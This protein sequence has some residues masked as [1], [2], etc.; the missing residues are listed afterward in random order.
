MNQLQI[1][2]LNDDEATLVV[3]LIGKVPGKEAEAKL[4]EIFVA[5]PDLRQAA[6]IALAGR[7]IV[8]WGRVEPL[9]RQYDGV[10]AAVLAAAHAAPSATQRI[11]RM[12]AFGDFDKR[13]SATYIATQMKDAKLLP[14]L[15]TLVDHVDNIH[16]PGDAYL[17]RQAI[18]AI[19]MTKVAEAAQRITLR[20]TEVIQETPTPRRPGS[21][22]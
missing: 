15:W 2:G 4:V 12:L 20:T 11:E 7:A 13:L 9:T 8:D 18:G 16:Y 17:R 3:Y 19:L 5:R 10:G 22:G 6:G 1:P 14:S 21:G